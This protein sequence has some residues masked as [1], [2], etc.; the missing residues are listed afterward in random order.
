MRFRYFRMTLRIIALEVIH[1]PLALGDHLQEA[2]ARTVI[3]GVLFEMF[4]KAVYLL[5]K[6]GNLNFRGAR[7]AILWRVFRN[8][9]CFLRRRKH[10]YNSVCIKI[11]LASL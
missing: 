8:D 3:F 6:K 5:T 1:Q 4:R 11:D 2:A 9:L 7:V 10:G